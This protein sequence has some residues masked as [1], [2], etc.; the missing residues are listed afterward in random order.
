MSSGGGGAPSGAGG[1]GGRCE[2][3]SMTWLAFGPASGVAAVSCESGTA[4]SG[5]A[6]RSHAICDAYSRSSRPCTS[7]CRASQPPLLSTASA[8]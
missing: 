1:G 7:A 5:A 4:A 2:E 3:K 8:P 6:P